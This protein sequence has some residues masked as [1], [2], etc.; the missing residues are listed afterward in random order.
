MQQI[1]L[2][3]GLY[4]YDTVNEC[5]LYTKCLKKDNINLIK[6][7]IINNRFEINLTYFLLPLQPIRKEYCDNI[8]FWQF[9]SLVWQNSV[10]FPSEPDIDKRILAIDQ[11]WEFKFSSSFG[12]ES[13]FK[14]DVRQYLN[15]TFIIAFQP[16]S[17]VQ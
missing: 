3:N 15:S 4:D 5:L 9:T 6:W 8:S 2:I 17:S 7:D 11:L 13:T 12:N 14:T 1:E 10:V 16:L